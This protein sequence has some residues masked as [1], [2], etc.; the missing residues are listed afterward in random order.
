MRS[1]NQDKGEVK[2]YQDGELVDE[3]EY[4]GRILHYNTEKKIYLG[5]SPSLEHNKRRPFKGTI[6][7]FALF[8][9]SLEPTQIKEISTNTGLGLTESYGAYIAPHTLEMCL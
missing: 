7:Y 5:N 2:F 9:H 6:D 4:E 3:T 1:V 8:N